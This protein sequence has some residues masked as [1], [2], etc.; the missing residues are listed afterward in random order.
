MDMECCVEWQSAHVQCVVINRVVNVILDGTQSTHTEQENNE[1]ESHVL[2]WCLS[3]TEKVSAEEQLNE[4]SSLP[5][6]LA[7]SLSRTTMW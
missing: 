2:P 5:T 3:R 7:L 1:S 4:K 6:V